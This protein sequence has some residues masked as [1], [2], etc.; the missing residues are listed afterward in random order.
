M[1][2]IVQVFIYNTPSIF[3]GGISIWNIQASTIY[4]QRF[5]IELALQNFWKY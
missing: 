1:F 2:R 3:I 4:I 5:I